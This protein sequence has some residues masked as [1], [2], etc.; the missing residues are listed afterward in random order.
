MAILLI[1]NKQVSILKDFTKNN[2]ISLHLL[3]L[4]IYRDD[5]EA[6]WHEYHKLTWEHVTINII[7]RYS[8]L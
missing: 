4:N 1:S 7:S 2:K 8:H 5:H 6:A 3:E